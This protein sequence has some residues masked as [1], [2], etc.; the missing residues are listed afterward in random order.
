MD[1]NRRHSNDRRFFSISINGK[2]LIALV[3][4]V[5]LLL[6]FGIPVNYLIFTLPDDEKNI[7]TWA[8]VCLLVFAVVILMVVL[9]VK[10]SIGQMMSVLNQD[11]FQ[12]M[13]M[14]Q[15]FQQ[16]RQHNRELGVMTRQLLRKEQHQQTGSLAQYRPEMPH[17]QIYDPASLDAVYDEVSVGE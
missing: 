9:L 15:V 2:Q 17:Q 8:L 5:V 1:R 4:A 12:D 13:D 10:V 3:T 11:H 16:M 7:L 6:V 14:M